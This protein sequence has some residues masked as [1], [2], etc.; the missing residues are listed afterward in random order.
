MANPW[1]K[2]SAGE[3]PWDRPAQAQPEKGNMYTQSAEDIQYDP[4]SGVPLNTSS[5]GSGTTGATDYARKALTTA[6]ALPINVATGVA[7]NV[8]GLAQ[9]VNRYFGEE[10]QQG[11]LSK[12]EEFLNAI[13]QIE[14][15]TQQQAGSP[16]LL[17]GASMVGQAA[18]W[19]ATGGAIG[20]I[21]SYLNTAKN[22]G[23]GIAMGGASA[24]ATPEE[25]GMSPEEFRAAK[26]KNIAIQ[27][28][29]GGTLPAVGGLV[30]ALRGAKQT[31]QMTQAIENAREAGY[32]MP[33]TQ[34]GGGILSRTLEG[35][36]GKA[37]TAQAASIKN[38]EITNKLATKSLGL[39]EDTVLSPEVIKSVRDTA[40]QTY[41]KLKNTGEIITTDAYNKALDKIIEPFIKTAKAFPDAEISPVIK[42][43]S[44]LRTG[45]VEASAAVE[46][47]K[48]LRTAA[49]DAY[50]TGNTEIGKANKDAAKALEDAI[51]VHLTANYSPG[52]L[53]QFKDARELI[54]KTYTV[55]NAMNKTTGTVDAKKLADRLQRGKPMSEEL[56][57]VAQFGQAFP[58]AIQTP[59]RIGGA[60]GT[61]PL[62]WTMAG[63][64]GGSA[65]LGGE[66]KSTSGALGLATLLARPGARRLALS[67]PVQ[68]RL[69][70]QATVPGTVRQALPSAEETKQLAKMLLM[71]RLGNTS[72]N[73]NE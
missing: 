56:K 12:P 49:D 50:R 42:Q 7:K 45:S 65:F 40:G 8:G 3:N 69:A 39:P 14:T 54:A 43:I 73:R 61:S 20:A 6:A 19:F 17:K 66:D 18:P 28:A 30:S 2:P 15:G 60:L 63:V 31:P 1:D 44:G 34:A 21:P 16:N 23:T 5:Y 10:S 59:E 33:P 24:L 37:S 71:Q 53:K 64:T 51:E 57:Q 36:A 70:Q 26:N 9:T 32:T 38:Q 25:I 68:N 62:D 29:I 52:L 72:E 35:L 13:N 41:E 55:E 67:G 46:K 27:G 4:I 48:Q 47:I 58:K 11:N 22:I